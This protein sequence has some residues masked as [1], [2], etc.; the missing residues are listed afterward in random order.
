MAILFYVTERP[1]RHKHCL[2]NVVN[3]MGFPGGSD[4]KE[5]A[6]LFL[7][8]DPRFREDA[9]YLFNILAHYSVLYL[10]Q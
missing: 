3:I 1:R 10:I 2:A 8:K 7:K 9:C 5:F 6:S 4:G